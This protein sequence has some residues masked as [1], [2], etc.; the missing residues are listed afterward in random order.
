MRLSILGHIMR[1]GSPSAHD[2]YLGTLFGAEAVR[3]LA[4]GESGSM[5]GL[6][7]NQFVTTPLAEVCARKAELDPG[8]LELARM[9]AK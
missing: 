8:Y 5:V 4:A 9:L 6:R 1:G 7:D 2:R 3:L